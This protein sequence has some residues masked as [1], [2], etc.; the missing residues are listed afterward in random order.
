MFQFGK[1]VNKATEYHRFPGQDQT[2][3]TLRPRRRIGRDCQI[4]PKAR[5]EFIFM[6][7]IGL[8]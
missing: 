1:D 5:L 2:P 8:G 6:G 4:N 3:D 7:A